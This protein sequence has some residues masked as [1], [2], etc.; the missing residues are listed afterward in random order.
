MKLQGKTIVS[1]SD[2]HSFW[3]WRL[4]RECTIFKN[5]DSYKEIIR[6]IRENDIIGTVEVNPAYGMYHYDGHRNCNFSCSPE[7][8]KKLKFQRQKSLN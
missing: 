8:T 3:P 4:G 5:I 2:S 1:F 6:E 7:E